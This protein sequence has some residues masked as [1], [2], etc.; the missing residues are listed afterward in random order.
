M[1]QLLLRTD[2]VLPY[3][4]R[5]VSSSSIHSSIRI[6]DLFSFKVVAYSVGASRAICFRFSLVVH[7]LNNAHR[8]CY[9]Q[10]DLNPSYILESWKWQSCEHVEC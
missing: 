8:C 6:P 5:G 9:D 10:N 7:N 3:V 4:L 2:S 1:E